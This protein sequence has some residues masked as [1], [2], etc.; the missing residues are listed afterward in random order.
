MPEDTVFVTILR[1]PVRQFESLYGYY[2]LKSYYGVDISKLN[3]LPSRIRDMIVK[4]SQRAHGKFGF[5]Q[6]LFDLGFDAMNKSVD[7][8]D[9]FIQLLDKQFDL[10]MIADFMPESLI[11]LKS[12]L[13]WDYSDVTVFKACTYQN[14]W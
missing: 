11:F 13:I 6:M 8:V 12:L 5:N 14:C 9:D 7:E 10:V 2:N 1:N 4:P 3:D